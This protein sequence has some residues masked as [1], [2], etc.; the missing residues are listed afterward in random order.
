VLHQHVPNTAETSLAASGPAERRVG[1]DSDKFHRLL[2]VSKNPDV[3]FKN[4]E[5]NGQDLIMTAVCIR[6][7][8]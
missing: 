1:R 4:D 5:R 6:L 8:C 7:L 3:M 2:V